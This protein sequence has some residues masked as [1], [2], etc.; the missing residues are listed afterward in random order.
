[1]RHLRHGDLEYR[2]LADTW[3]NNGAFVCCCNHIGMYDVFG[4]EPKYDATGLEGLGVV[5]RCNMVFFIDF[6][7]FD[8]RNRI[9]RA[10][11]DC[12]GSFFLVQQERPLT[13]QR[14]KAFFKAFKNKLP[15]HLLFDL[16]YSHYELLLLY[17]KSHYCQ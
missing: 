5:D 2:V 15:F 14:K 1:M 16:F 9:E 7:D 17:K 3:N 13:L 4:G 12:G 11:H 8:G 10:L 6:P